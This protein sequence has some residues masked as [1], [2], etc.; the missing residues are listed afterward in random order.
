MTVSPKKMSTPSKSDL[1]AT[2][3][4]ECSLNS[5]SPSDLVGFPLKVFLS[6]DLPRWLSLEDKIHRSPPHNSSHFWVQGVPDQVSS[7]SVVLQDE[8][9]VGKDPWTSFPFLLVDMDNIFYALSENWLKDFLDKGGKKI[10]AYTSSKLL[11][12]IKHS[13]FLEDIVLPSKGA[14][15]DLAIRGFGDKPSLQ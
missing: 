2:F 6:G 1:W 9:Y 8:C 7:W 14:L 13:R 3:Y 12:G 15:L 4:L 10:L 5:P 11:F